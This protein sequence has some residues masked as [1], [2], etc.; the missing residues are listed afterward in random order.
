MTT[1]RKEIL[2][3]MESHKETWDDVVSNTL[4]EQELDVEFNNGY[5]GTN[6]IPF[7]LWTKNRV[8]FP[9]QYD[10][11]EWVSSVSRNPDG[12]ATEHVGGG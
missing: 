7:T 12:R 5:G 10:G 1:W 11:S 6:G 4:T 8:Y 3:E 9:V 2:N